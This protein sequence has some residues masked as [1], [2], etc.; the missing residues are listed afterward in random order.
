MLIL[1]SQ[2][3][4]TIIVCNIFLF[5]APITAADIHR[6]KTSWR[7]NHIYIPTD[8]R[9]LHT[10]QMFLFKIYE[11][12]IFDIV[13]IIHTIVSHRTRFPLGGMFWKGS[14]PTADGHSNLPYVSFCIEISF[15]I[16]FLHMV[17]IKSVF[18]YRG[19]LKTIYLRITVL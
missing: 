11:S 10:L 16:S 5:V 14:H 3:S 9:R 17:E 8:C 18:Y 6:T 13:H 2:K 4:P 15:M 1:Q 12:S 19:P 7:A